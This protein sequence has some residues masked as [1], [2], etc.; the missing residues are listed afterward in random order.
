[1]SQSQVDATGL[2][3]QLLE[4]ES[5]EINGHALLQYSFGFDACAGKS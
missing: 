2:F 1:M 3:C 4:M 5:G